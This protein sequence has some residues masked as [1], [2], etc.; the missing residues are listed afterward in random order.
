MDETDHDRTMIELANRFIEA[1]AA[2]D[3]DALRAL[4]HP[5][6][7]MWHNTDQ[8]ELSR[9][10][11]LESYRSNNSRVLA[12]HYHDVRIMPFKGGYTQQHRIV[13]ELADGGELNIACCL[14]ARVEGELIKR[15]DEYYDSG[16]FVA[17][18]LG[19]PRH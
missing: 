4:Y 6:L 19:T 18:G 12:I 2:R 3:L 9:E 11:H 14:I 7:V 1:A 5:D 15:L 10:R 13:A 8:I 16:A 17:A